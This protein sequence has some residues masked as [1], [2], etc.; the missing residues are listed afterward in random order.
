[1]TA[2]SASTPALPSSRAALVVLPWLV[3]LRWVSV[4]GLAAGIAAASVFWGVR[5][6]LGPLVALLAAMAATNI[7]LAFQLRAPEPSRVVIGASLLVDS[8][9]LTGILYFAGGPMNPF[10]IVYLVGI[11]LAAV[12]LGHR[13]AMAIATASV[14]AYG[15]TFFW[16]RPLEF[17]DP[18]QSQHTM[19]LHLSGMWVALS[20]AAALIAYF[21]GR[22]SEALEQRERELTDARAATARSERLAALLSLG[23]GAAHE[24]ATPLSTIRTAAG[25]LGRAMDGVA[26]A[27]DPRAHEYI[28][29]IRRETDRCTHVLDQLSGRAASASAADTQIALAHLVD[30]VRNRLGDARAARLEVA[31]PASPQ[32]IAAPAE[33]LRQAVVALLQNAFDASAPGQAVTLRVEQGDGVRVEV[34]D[35]GRGMSDEDVARAGEPFFTTKAPGAGL[36]LGL[37]LVR[38]FADQMG[39]TLRVRS[40]LGKGTSV[41][42][43]LPAR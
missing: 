21:V 3:R 37:F 43:D 9:L 11:T 20:A 14:A 23:A 2:A 7:V 36:G 24:L 33:P 8:G 4:V 1:M 28:G 15:L 39:G 34:V 35:R 25:E 12:T 40:G 6:P 16:N 22:V 27:S 26:T 17:I 31:L 10:S 19:T 30:D 32:P 29:V 13:W 41:I 18:S 42:L 38:A 5:V